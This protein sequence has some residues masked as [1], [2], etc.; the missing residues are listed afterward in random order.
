MPFSEQIVNGE[1][2]AMTPHRPRLFRSTSVVAGMTLISRVMGFIRD[3]VLAQAFG[4]GAA[5]DAFVIALKLPNFFRRLFGEGA[6]SQAFVPVLADIKANESPAEVQDFLNRV[7]GTL[8]LI[9]TVIVI[10]AEIATPFTVFLFAPGFAHDDIRY[11]LT[12]HMLHITF[13]YL[14]LIVMTAFCG[15]ILNTWNSFS[16][17]AF[18]PVMLNVA[19]IGTAWWWAPHSS[20]PIYTLAWGLLIGGV[21]QLLLQL[22]A[23][24]RRNLLPKLTL[25]FRDV[26]VKKVMRLMIPALFGVSVAQIGLFIDSFFASYL[27]K[28]SIS[29]L[30]Y[31]D[32]LIY[33][34]LGVI[35]VAL[36][37]VVLPH[38]SRHHSTQ[39][40]QHY[41]DTIDWALRME[42]LAGIPATV[43]LFILAG[44]ILATLIH[45]G[46]FTVNDVIMTRKSLQTLSIGLPAFMLIKV[47]SSAFYSRK[48]IRTP[49]KIAA[50]A[51][52]AN[53]IL[54]IALIHTFRHAGL[55]LA[56]SLAAIFNAGCLAFLLKKRDVYHPTRGW[57]IFLTRLV[58]ANTTMGI[59]I[60]KVAGSLEHWLT[61]SLM[62]RIEHLMMVILAGI[63][64][65]FVTL[66][67]L[68]MRLRNLRHL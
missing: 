25:G 56:T 21:I 64:V 44:P 23:L 54:N 16:I 32:R 45:H 39:N 9:V 28:G 33:L 22:P 60:W 19:M 55:A 46:A 27:P 62:Q 37:T 50:Y 5:F 49:V 63:L 13:P 42:L 29:W 12:V 20:Q 31:S 35:G 8:G 18:A 38:L 53:I 6:F 52:G 10:L 51:V 17:T 7:A 1:A 30:Y 41:S 48:D 36:A 40:H 24:K 58:L 4:A 61:W 65:Y 59:C 47:L 3:M 2:K 68:G 26:R 15:A 43:A 14:L 11:Q 66:G 67:M 34:P 57:K